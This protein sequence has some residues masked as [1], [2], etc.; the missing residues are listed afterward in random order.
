MRQT[1]TISVRAELRPLDREFYTRPTL[2]VAEELLGKCLVRQVDGA[3]LVG[4]I[5]EVEA[6]IGEDD[7]ACH[8]RFGRTERNSVMYGR[9]GFSYI[10]FIYGMYNMFNIVTER[11]GFPAAV[12]VRAVEPLEGIDAM[13]RL[14]GTTSVGNLSNGPGKLC[15]AFGLDTSHSGIDLTG[16]AIYVSGCESADHSVGV[17][18]RI[19]IKQG[20]ER[21]WR[22]YIEGNRFVSRSA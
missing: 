20:T 13:Q 11:E 7:P 19:G 4:R 1:S 2:T 10:Y 17:S 14:R 6:Y 12:L 21:K 8:A 22:F 5:V 3:A 16:K 18:S 15:R 9:G